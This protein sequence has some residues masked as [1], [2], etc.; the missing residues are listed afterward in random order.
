MRAAVG[1]V[2][3]GIL[4]AGCQAPRSTV[5]PGVPPSLYEVP[6]NYYHYRYSRKL[7]RKV[8]EIIP[9]KDLTPIKKPKREV[10]DTGDSNFDEAAASLYKARENAAK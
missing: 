5:T 3:V 2:C 7:H 10:V 6:A 8:R 9:A 4:M 1:L